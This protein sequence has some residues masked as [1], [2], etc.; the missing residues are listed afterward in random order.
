M[1][2]IQIFPTF[3]LINK[4]TK[5][6]RKIQITQILMVSISISYI[7]CA[8]ISAAIFCNLLFTVQKIPTKRQFLFFVTNDQGSNL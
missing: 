2:E 1:R 4:K 6:G 5:R 8:L 7:F 3:W